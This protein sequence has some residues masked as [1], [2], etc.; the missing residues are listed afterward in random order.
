MSLLCMSL[1][2]SW[3]NVGFLSVDKCRNAPLWQTRTHLG[4]HKD[5]ST[6]RLSTKHTRARARTQNKKQHHRAIPGRSVSTWESCGKTR[7]LYWNCFFAPFAFLWS[8]QSYYQGP[9]RLTQKKQTKEKQTHQTGYILLDPQPRL[10]GLVRVC[11]GPTAS[12]C[13][14]RISWQR[15]FSL[16]AGACW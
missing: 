11:F 12:L 4:V 15:W 7:R 9:F 5:I 6:S 16:G 10:P 2:A 3:K 14:G 13:T 1:C 8:H